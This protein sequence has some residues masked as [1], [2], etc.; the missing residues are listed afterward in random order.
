MRP[1]PNQEREWL[2]RYQ[3]EWY[4][5]GISFPWDS[6]ED[7]EIISLETD[8]GEPID[9]DQIP[10]SLLY[11]LYSCIDQMVQEEISERIEAIRD[12]YLNR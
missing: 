9:I 1:T 2:T 6:I 5:I 8:Q 12:T 3:G 7:T 11:G 4:N 10:D